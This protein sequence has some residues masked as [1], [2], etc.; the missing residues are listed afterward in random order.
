V[1]VAELSKHPG[2]ML[3]DASLR[4]VATDRRAQSG[5]ED[6]LIQY[7]ARVQT[8]R[9]KRGRAR[10]Q[11]EWWAWLRLGFAV[12]AEKRR[13]PRRPVPGSDSTD[14]EEKIRAGIAG[15]QLVAT[16]L[17]R[18][19]G[20]EWTLLRGYRNR[21]GE[22]DHLVLGPRGLF[23][24]E[25]KNINATV[26]VSGDLWRADKYDN[27]GNLVERRPITDR[28]GRSPSEQLNESA[29]E[30][31]RFLRERGQPV[32]VHRVVVLA[33]RRSRLGS[34]ENLTVRVGTSPAYVLSLLGDS[35]EQL[36]E[37]QC[38]EIQRLI[39]RDHDF[40]E[41]GRRRPGPSGGRPRARNR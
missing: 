10:A 1:Q 2:D 16:E 24:I 4:R 14:A 19:L 36:G 13:R 18:A 3:T 33:H 11:H 38:L 7:Q 34:R 30:L 27:Y 5:Y 31:Q 17:S 35:P 12:L 21:R 29:D 26:H 28:R 41:R 25:V 32:A 20:D 23:A 39:R 9:V 37:R 8:L 15:E 22:I 6:A 40:H